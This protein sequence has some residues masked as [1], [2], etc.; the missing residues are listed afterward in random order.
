MTIQ[1]QLDQM[2][3]C[4]NSLESE[5]KSVLMRGLAQM[6][7]TTTLENWVK[8][9]HAK[10]DLARLVAGICPS[11]GFEVSVDRKQLGG[12]T[13]WAY[14]CDCGESNSIFLSR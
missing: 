12:R 8:K 2:T 10:A 14:N 11:C 7:G 1:E 5:E 3:D 9:H 6:Y 13:E 4:I